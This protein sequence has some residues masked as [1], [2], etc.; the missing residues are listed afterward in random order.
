MAAKGSAGGP[1][2]FKVWAPECRDEECSAGYRQSQLK[3]A[4]YAWHPHQSQ[5]P[6]TAEEAR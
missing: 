4:V 5:R 2:A 6:Y 1:G 3:N